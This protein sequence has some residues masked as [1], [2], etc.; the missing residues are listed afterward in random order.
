MMCGLQDA[1]ALRNRLMFS[2]DFSRL[3]WDEEVPHC[4]LFLPATHKGL[5]NYEEVI[6]VHIN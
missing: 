5:T 2:V 6:F 3:P 1:Y 4:P